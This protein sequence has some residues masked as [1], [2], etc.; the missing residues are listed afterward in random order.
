MIYTDFSKKFRDVE[1]ECQLALVECFKEMGITELKIPHYELE[2]NNED[3]EET[4][5]SV[6]NDWNGGADNLILHKIILHPT[7]WGGT[8]QVETEDGTYWLGECID[9]TIFTLYERAYIE[10]QKLKPNENE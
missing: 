2:L 1:T 8:F 5:I 6:Y 3:V 4:I 10:L 9:G 7:N